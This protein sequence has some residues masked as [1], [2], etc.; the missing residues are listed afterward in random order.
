M[1]KRTPPRALFKYRLRLALRSTTPDLHP[2]ITTHNPHKMPQGRAFT[3]MRNNFDQRQANNGAENEP[4]PVLPM[5]VQPEVG[6]ILF[7][8]Y[9]EHTFGRVLLPNLPAAKGALADEARRLLRPWCF[10]EGEYI[11]LCVPCPRVGCP[12]NREKRWPGVVQA[13]MADTRWSTRHVLNK[14]GNGS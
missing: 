6:A 4:S 5:N 8:K 2:S 13:E 12:V 11:R 9:G 1:L 10:Q 3:C 14:N 7:Y